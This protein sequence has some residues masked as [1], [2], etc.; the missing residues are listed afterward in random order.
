MEDKKAEIFRCG[1]ELFSSKGFKDTNVS[2]ITKLS[3]IAVGTFYNYYSSKEKLFLDIF[4][5]ENEQLKKNI[6]TSVDF[7]ETPSKL[8]KRLMELNISGMKANPILKQWYNTD[9]FGKIEQL[10]R[11]ENGVQSVNF[12]YDDFIELIRTWQKNGKMRNDIDCNLIMAF[13]TALINLDTHKEEI[14]IQYF[15]QLLDYM[16]DFIMDGLLDNSHK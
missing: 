12:L 7:N 10:Y 3:G 8:I 16:A 9:T 4:M 6:M 2:D 14:G 5:A 1:K 11:E 13:F 15:P